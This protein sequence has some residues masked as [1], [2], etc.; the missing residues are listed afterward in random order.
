MKW[1]KKKKLSQF[2][3]EQGSVGQLFRQLGS[4]R[5]EIDSLKFFSRTKFKFFTFK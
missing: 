5:E 2:T 1:N 4:N 3:W